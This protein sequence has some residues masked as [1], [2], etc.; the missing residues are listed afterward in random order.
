VTAA[1][2]RKNYDSTTSAAATPTITIGSVAGTDTASFSETYDSKH[3]GTGKTLNPAGTV[4]DGNGGANYKVT[5]ASSAN[6]EID[7][8]GLTV[9]ATGVNKQYDGTPSATVTLS[10]NRIS[11]DVFTDSYTS[12]SFADKNV[13]TG[14]AVSVSG[15]SISGTD[16]GNY[17]LST[18]TA[19]TTANITVRCIT[20]TAAANR[21]NYDSTTSAAATPTIT[22]G[23]V[24][25]T[26][27][28]SFSET[29]DSKH[30]GTGKTLNPAG[31]VNDGNG[32]ANYKV[33]FA[34]SA[35]GEI[36]AI[37]LTVTATGVNKQY[38]GTPSATV[39][40]SDNRIS[41]DVFTDSYTSASFADKNVETGKA[42]SVSGLSISGTDAGNYTLSTTTAT[43]TANITV[44]C[45]T[46]TAAANRKNYDSTTSAAATPT[47]TIGSV[48]GTDTASF[49]ETYDSKHVGTGK[50]LNPAGTVND[51]NGGANYKVTFASSANGEIDAIGL[52]V[53][54][55]GVNKQY[56]GTPS[57]TVT[58]SDNRISGDVFTDSYTSASFADK[59][60]GTGKAVSVSGLSIS[61]TDARNYTLSTTTAT[62][63]AN[64]TV[65]PL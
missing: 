36:D 12:A 18:T 59:N 31:T 49:S 58:L 28:A 52:T 4:N 65:R 8:I 14:K 33:T 47:I 34:S 40:L 25:G 5:F 60:V 19:T 55:T 30:V 64:I 1:A 26:D 45:I 42:V 38:D 20:V 6:G 62:T 15:L 43:T 2:N 48:A 10:D 50:T 39:T 56:D 11:G 29:Y 27:T 53:T 54:A 46:V 32:G 22:I 9:T 41:G 17:T 37:G 57:A 7:A 24:A 23:S 35:N 16:A 51:G 3:V 44:R 63:T 61:G 21:K 13:E